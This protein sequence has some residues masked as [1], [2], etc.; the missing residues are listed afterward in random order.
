[1]KYL[2]KL[3]GKPDKVLENISFEK[4]IVQ[5]EAMGG[6]LTEIKEAS[7][8]DN[9]IENQKMKEVCWAE[10]VA[11]ALEFAKQLQET[12]FPN[13]AN[14]TVS[15]VPKLKKQRWVG[16]ANYFEKSI[17]LANN[18]LTDYDEMGWKQ[19]IY[20]EYLHH[21]F[22]GQGHTGA[23]FRKYEKNNPFRR[24]RTNRLSCMS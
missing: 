12:Y 21:K 20:H 13:L 14:I 9:M 8:L 5:V 16:Q 6:T 4:L 11:R 19:V 1:M 7:P 3:P 2:L 23:G 17:K 10:K 24:V 15:V 18:L 22:P